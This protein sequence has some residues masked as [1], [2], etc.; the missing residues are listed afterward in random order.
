MRIDPLRLDQRGVT[1]LELLLSVTIFLLVVL[2]LSTY[3]LSGV[4]RYQKTLKQSNLRNELD[5]TIADIMTKVEGASFFEIS[6]TGLETTDKR[7][8]DLLTIFQSPKLG[9][10]ISESEAQELKASLTTYKTHVTYEYDETLDRKVPRSEIVKQT[11]Q[12][13][14]FNFNHQLY[15]IDGLFKLSDDNKKL[16]VFLVVVPKSSYF[17]EMDGQHSGFTGWDEVVT[18]LEEDSPP[19]EYIKIT[20]IEIAVN[21]LQRG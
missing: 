19:F 16:L 3:Y 9:S 12:I 7:K 21:N 15:L 17:L 5:F 10:S 11:F 2:P 20:K 13:P 14:D 6:D 8:D 18:A 1:V 4:D